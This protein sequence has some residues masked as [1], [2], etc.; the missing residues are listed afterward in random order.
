MKNIVICDIISCM[1]IYTQ[2]PLMFMPTSVCS[3]EQLFEI[4]ELFMNF[5]LTQITVA[6]GY[7]PFLIITVHFFFRILIYSS[8]KEKFTIPYV[9]CCIYLKVVTDKYNPQVLLF[10]PQAHMHMCT[11]MHKHAHSHIH[12]DALY[13]IRFIQRGFPP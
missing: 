6:N 5:K 7:Q 13:G 12:T 1:Y 9:A 8:H 10:L 2:N 4:V 11:H 3:S